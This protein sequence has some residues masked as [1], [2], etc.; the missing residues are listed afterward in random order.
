MEAGF[1]GAVGTIEM[2]SQT[3]LNCPECDYLTQDREVRKAR[4]WLTKVYHKGGRKG[5]CFI[6][7]YRMKRNSHISVNSLKRAEARIKELEAEN[8]KLKEQLKEMDDMCGP[9]LLEEFGL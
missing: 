6:R 3:L 7:E 8:Q 5:Q 4:G 2:N 1:Y 9:T